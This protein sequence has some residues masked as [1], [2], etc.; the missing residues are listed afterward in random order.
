MLTNLSLFILFTPL[1]LR[2]RFRNRQIHYNSREK[3]I[4]GSSLP[5][6]K[7]QV[8]REILPQ[9]N[10]AIKTINGAVGKAI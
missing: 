9:I 5:S 6:C 3:S 1:V 2:P 4:G 7:L 10:N 8:H